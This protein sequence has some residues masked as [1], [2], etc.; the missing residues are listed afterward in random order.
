MMLSAH[1]KSPA[2]IN[3]IFCQKPKLGS[4]LGLVIEGFR[5]YLWSRRPIGQKI[6]G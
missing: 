3:P 4:N 6:Y 5:A 1:R 2:E